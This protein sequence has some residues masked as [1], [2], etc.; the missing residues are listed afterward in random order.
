VLSN[1]G[2]VFEV[3]FDGACGEGPNGKRQEYDWE[4]FVRTVRRLQPG[5][6]IFSDVGPDVRWVGNESGIA[7]ETC[8]SMLSPAGFTPGAAGPPAEVLN[9][10]EENGTHWIPPECDVSIRPGW[11]YHAE[12][13]G[14]VKSLATLV[15]IWEG[16]VGRNG[17]LLLNL[18]VDR[19][20]LVHEND[21]Q[22]LLELRRWVDSAY[23]DDLARGARASASNERGGSPSFCA[24][25]AI[26]GD[27]ASYWATDDDVREATLELDL[28]RAA[29]LH[30][31]SCCASRSRSASASRGS[32]SRSGAPSTDAGS[33]SP[34]ARRSATAASCA[35]PS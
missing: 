6:V 21:A 13:D 1:Y 31:A 29:D 3:W 28:P 23:A 4:G 20:G 33:P 17:N 19:R 26:D 12:Q 32:G 22:R 9:R 11:Y 24:G 2:P 16:S 35:C 25:E 5:A 8:W 34:R 30:T 27:P 15:D 14:D 18:P 10:G 7:G